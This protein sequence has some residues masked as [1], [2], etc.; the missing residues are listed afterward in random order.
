MRLDW[1][2][3]HW[4][5]ELHSEKYEPKGNERERETEPSNKQTKETRGGTGRD[6]ARLRR[7]LE[8]SPVAVGRFRVGVSDFS[9]GSE[10]SGIPDATTFQ[11][12]FRV[13]HPSVGN[14]SS[15]ASAFCFADHR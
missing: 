10:S 15:A 2:R 8:T 14:G 4:F 11:G 5:R 9:V 3:V 6:A 7:H 1:F 13:D 12:T